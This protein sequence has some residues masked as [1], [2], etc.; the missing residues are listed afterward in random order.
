MV[1]ISGRREHPFEISIG[2]R[3]PHDL[4]QIRNGHNARHRLRRLSNQST[5]QRIFDRALQHHIPFM[6]QQSDFIRFT[7]CQGRDGSQRRL[8][9]FADCFALDDRSHDGNLIVPLP[10]TDDGPAGQLFREPFALQIAHASAQ[11]DHALV[12]LA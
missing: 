3:S 9:Q 8:H 10:Q 2:S 12:E 11:S 7:A 1:P 5:V 6:D 4:Q